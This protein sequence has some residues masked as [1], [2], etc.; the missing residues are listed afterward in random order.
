MSGRRRVVVA[1]PDTITAKMAG[2]AIRAWHIASLLAEEH[3]V[4]LV[5]TSHCELTP[6]G[7]R[8]GAADDGRMQELEQ[9]CDVFILQ[10]WIMAGRPYLLTSEKVIVVDVYDPLHLEQLEQTRDEE[11]QRRRDL[12]RGSVAVLN[13]Q[14]MRGDFFLCA[15]AK[16]RDFWLGQLAALGRLNARTYDE[17]ETM[18]RL[19]SVVP[20][21]ISE[22]APVHQRPA[23]RGVVPGIGPGDKLVLWA[24][25]VYNWFDPL[26]LIRAIDVLRARLPHV[27]LYFMGMSHPN[28]EIP[29][30]RMAVDAL[31]LAEDLGLT[32]THVFFN[33]GWV[34]YED[35]QNFLLEADVGVS[36]H[37]DHV[38]TAFSF[39]TRILD[40]LWASLPIVSTKGDAFAEWIESEDL[41]RTVAPGDVDGLADA[42]FE[43]LSDPHQAARCSANVATMAA[44]FTWPHVLAPLVDFCRHPR[45]APDLLDPVTAQVIPSDVAALHPATPGWRH[46]VRVAAQYL[47]DGGVGLVVRRAVARLRRVMSRNADERP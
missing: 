33:D 12:I 26:T 43:L 45:R 27:R 8:A 39:R 42:L 37:L 21:G 25:G 1:T 44:R 32:G 10:G 13:E 7:F 41:G 31:A 23:I 47:Q 15:S 30:M 16:Q 4:E 40:Y 14:L 18:E 2:P 38:E 3:D 9:W 35:R 19:I 29:Q 36:T 20:F 24:G 6:T 11:P 28:P 5:T 17:D 22:T 34:A 46:D